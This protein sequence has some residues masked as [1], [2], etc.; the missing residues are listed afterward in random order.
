M[1]LGICFHHSSHQAVNLVSGTVTT[2]K[3]T[4]N[5][6]IK[7]HFTI[8]WNF[9]SQWE[10][11]ISESEKICTNQISVPGNR[12]G[13]FC[14]HNKTS[15]E[16]HDGLTWFVWGLWGYLGITRCS[17]L[18]F[19]FRNIFRLNLHFFCVI[20]PFF[21]PLRGELVLLFSLHFFAVVVLG[22]LFSFPSTYF[23]IFSLC[24]MCSLVVRVNTWCC[25]FLLRC[26]CF[27]CLFF[28]SVLVF[29]FYISAGVVT[30]FCWPRD[31]T[32][33]PFLPSFLGLTC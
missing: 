16:C 12:W 8:W 2:S 23:Y 5:D 4:S 33:L 3:G 21:P 20:I 7:T 17:F 14:Q 31:T 32:V 19:S 26:F 27:S 30:D 28:L 11:V 18:L 9:V 29:V 6:P 22:L 10:V 24:N 13:I 25:I 15:W 1:V